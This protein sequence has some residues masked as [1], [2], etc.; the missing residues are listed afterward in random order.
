MIDIN[1]LELLIVMRPSFLS[2]SV[3]CVI[4]VLGQ[5]NISLSQSSII[6]KL[7]KIGS[8]FERITFDTCNA[9]R[10]SHA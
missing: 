3:L 2:L 8:A 6:L 1:A 10:V 9:A 5:I 4:T 7:S